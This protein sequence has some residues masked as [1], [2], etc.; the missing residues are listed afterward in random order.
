MC[1][2]IIEKLTKVGLER[3]RLSPTF[4][5]YLDLFPLLSRRK[6]EEEKKGKKK[7]KKHLIDL[8]IPVRHVPLSE[9]NLCREFYRCSRRTKYPDAHLSRI[10]HTYTYSLNEP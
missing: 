9:T 10:T 7:D 6:K 8:Q 5:I 4:R 3:D 1:F 2:D